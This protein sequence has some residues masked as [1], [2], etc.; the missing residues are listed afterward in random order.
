MTEDRP[1]YLRIVEEIR[2]KIDSGELASGDRLPSRPEIMRDYGVSN[3]VALQVGRVLVSEGLAEAR[4]GSGTYVRQRRKPQRLVRSF[5]LRLGTAEGSPYQA[6]MQRQGRRAAWTY[7]SRT[8]IAPEDIRERLA[9]GEA[10][11]DED[12][13]RTEYVFMSD[14]EPSELSTSWEPLDLTIGTP[15]V[16]PEDGPAVGVMD[17]MR[18]IGIT[19]D[20]AEER[21]RA[22]IGTAEEC[23][24]LR[25]PPGS[26]VFAIVRMY[27]AKGRPV[28]TADIVMSSER[29]ELVYGE[30]VPPRPAG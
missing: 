15:V 21:I 19:I 29:Y 14:D 12:V 24:A 7:K 17:R 22:R 30:Q 23:S 5:T 1:L 8:T 9:L 3:S 26:I 25:L 13:V 18:V 11:P 10:G 27:Y 28:E 2:A 16:M 4:S 6:D 20:G